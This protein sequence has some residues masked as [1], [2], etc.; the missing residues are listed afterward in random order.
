MSSLSNVKASGNVEIVTKAVVPGMANYPPNNQ[1]GL[2]IVSIV[3]MSSK[4][5]NF[6][7]LGTKK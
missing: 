7:K 4:R 6:N 5:K 2:T 1:S 3:C